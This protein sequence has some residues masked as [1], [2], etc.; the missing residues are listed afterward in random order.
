MKFLLSVATV[1]SFVGVVEFG[2]RA[3]P[4]DSVPRSASRAAANVPVPRAEQE[5][6]KKI[7]KAWQDREERTR[8]LVL[9]YATKVQV[10]SQPGGPDQP[11]R[12]GQRRMT[13]LFLLAMRGDRLRTEY[14]PVP[15]EDKLKSLLAN[16]A[17][18]TNSE[19]ACVEFG[20]R[21][22]TLYPRVKEVDGTTHPRVEIAARTDQ[23]AYTQT[24][25]LLLLDYRSGTRVLLERF[26]WDRLRLKVEPGHRTQ[27]ARVIMS[28]NGHE[29]WLDPSRDYVV[30]RLIDYG[31]GRVETCTK[32]CDYAKAPA[33]I[34][35]IPTKWTITSHTPDGTFL[36]R[37]ESVLIDWGAGADK[38]PNEWF[39]LEYADGTLI[40]DAT[41]AEGPS[42]KCSI[43]WHGKLVPASPFRPYAAA[44]ERVKQGL[45]PDGK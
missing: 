27:S 23:L 42:T 18:G 25:E 7:R 43:A 35:W 41:E 39:N 5:L 2:D 15:S 30:T 45:L 22:L 10:G 36:R 26:P 16:L 32:E 13:G 28:V 33:P 34:E 1:V 12:S 3:H 31:P 21:T 8:A 14:W 17:P 11:R 6:L 29:L 9:V 20:N 40:F 19:S 4:D 44:L 38:V 24:G 37:D